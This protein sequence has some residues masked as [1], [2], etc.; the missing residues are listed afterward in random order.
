MI[1]GCAG[2]EA[3]DEVR[4]NLKF[5]S[6]P[7][8]FGG[9][10]DDDGSSVS[11]VVA[12]RV[13]T[14]GT[15]ELCTGAL[16]APNVVLTAR[17]CVTKNLTSSV[18]CDEK[19]QSANGRHVASNEEVNA[20]GVYVGAAPS[21][22]QKPHAFAHAIVAPKSEHLCD[23]DIALVVLEK[24][25]EGVEPLKVR[26]DTKV[27]PGEMIRS[28]G[29]GQNDRRSPIGTRFRRDNVSVLAM[30]SAVSPSKTPLGPHEFEVGMSICQGDSGGPAISEETGAV[31]GVVSRGGSCD[32]DFGH[33]YTTTSGFRSMFD[34]AFAIAGGAPIVDDGVGTTR[35]MSKNTSSGSE[36]DSSDA[37]S[38][39]ATH[40]GAKGASPFALALAALLCLRRR[41][42][43]G[44]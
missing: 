30:G 19:G 11:G 41:R 34:E 26:I 9:N 16:I 12:L 13:G 42:Q 3:Q 31:I 23:G 27:I 25:L 32:E 1:T 17:H 35:T 40:V 24:N 28:V 38:C 37:G 22:A 7:S 14:G 15:F 4:T 44:K 6:E 5:R 29:Y 21:F 33:I 20:I 18:S 2:S 43:H 39:S 8:I 36:P 10:K